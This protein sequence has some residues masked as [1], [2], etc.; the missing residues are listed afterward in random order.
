MATVTSI[1]LSPSSAE[2]G[3]QTTATVKVST[4]YGSEQCD[5]RVYI[6]GLTTVGYKSNVNIAGTTT[7]S[8]TC[9]VPTTPDTY[10]VCAEVE[11]CTVISP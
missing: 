6:P 8:V 9:G 4:T 5:I 7:A 3:T 2:P 11:D 1:S 10:Q